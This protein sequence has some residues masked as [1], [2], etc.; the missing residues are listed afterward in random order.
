MVSEKKYFFD[1]IGEVVM[2]KKKGVRRLT[3][4]VNREGNV[5]VTLPFLISFKEAERFVARK[6]S[7]IVK[8]KNKHISEAKIS[9]R[10]GSI[11]HTRFHAI[12]IRRTTDEKSF[13]KN[14]VDKAEIMIPEKV[15]ISSAQAQEE[16]R[17][18]IREILRSEAKNY[19]IN[20]VDEL[21]GIYGF[22]YKKVYIKNLKSRWGSC[23]SVNNINLNLH[24]MRLPEKLSDYV[25]L[26][27]LM[28]T[29][30][31]NHGPG[32]WKAL[33]EI[34]GDTSAIRRELRKYNT[35]F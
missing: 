16:I 34:I 17:Y 33:H 13:R 14:S 3:I 7:W 4:R 12:E 23:S 2:R 8:T 28:H 24:L 11:F 27:E 25:I 20:R 15:N 21:A 10:E 26:H 1:E 6:R 30:H 18:H 35:Q 32:F 9:F 29:R 22:D 19:L 5:S 31:K